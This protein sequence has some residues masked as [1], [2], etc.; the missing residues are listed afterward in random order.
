MPAARR[1]TKDKPSTGTDVIDMFDP[2][3]VTKD[4]LLRY[5][6]VLH[7]LKDDYKPKRFYPPQLQQGEWCNFGHWPADATTYRHLENIIL[8]IYNELR[9]A[10]EADGPS[11]IL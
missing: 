2:R 11:L 3:D 4:T 7:C 10:V 8:M 9:V 1:G 6:K 5:G